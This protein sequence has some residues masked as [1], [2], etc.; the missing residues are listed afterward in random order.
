MRTLLEAQAAP[1]CTQQR[2]GSLTMTT[3]HIGL[4]EDTAQAARNAGLLMP[5]ALERML[6]DALKRKN[7]A[8]SLLLIAERVAARASSRCRWKR[9]TPK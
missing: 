9:S 1:V 4:P 8:D 5:Q 7:A 6:N 2:A 3:I